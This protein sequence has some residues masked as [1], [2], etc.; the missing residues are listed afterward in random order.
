MQNEPTLLVI[1][2]A[3]AMRWYHTVHIDQWRR[4]VAFIKA[5]KR[6]HRASSRSDIIK[7]DTPMPVDSYISS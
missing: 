4:F 3:M 1:M 6:R 2:M 5:T 7:P